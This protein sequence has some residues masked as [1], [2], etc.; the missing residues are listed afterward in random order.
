MIAGLAMK[1]FRHTLLALA[2]LLPLAAAC[3]RVP[4]DKRSAKLI[5]SYFE[6]YAKEYPTTVYGEYGVTEVDVVGQ[7]ELHKNYVA[8]DAFLALGNETVQRISATVE[9]GPFGWRFVSWENA[10]PQ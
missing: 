5:R 9:R 8:V 1:R 7:Q 4:S 2:L 6:D 3:A 10:S